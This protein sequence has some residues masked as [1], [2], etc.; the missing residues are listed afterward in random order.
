MLRVG[1]NVGSS[2]LKKNIRFFT[3]NVCHFAEHFENTFPKERKRAL[4]AVGREA[5]YPVVWKD[6][7]A[8][9]VRL[10]LSTIAE[11]SPGHFK[12]THESAFDRLL[13][14]QDSSHLVGLLSMRDGGM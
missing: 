13:T 11:R 3:S 4:R 2:I 9:D 8:A 14:S 10:L 6:G 5:E 1:S 7:T 12:A